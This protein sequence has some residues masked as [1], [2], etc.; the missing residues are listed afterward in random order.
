VTG[1]ADGVQLSLT[2]DD[3]RNLPAVDVHHPEIPTP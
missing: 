2:K 3:I 1:V